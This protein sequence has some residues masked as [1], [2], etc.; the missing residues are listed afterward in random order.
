MKTRKRKKAGFAANTKNNRVP[1]LSSI[2]FRVMFTV[3]IAVFIA[4]TA[5]LLVVTLPVRSELNAVNSEYLYMT[6]VLYGQKLETAV[7]L[8]KR[9]ND[10]RQAPDRLASFLQNA[11]LERCESSYS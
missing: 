10:I 4:V 11:R 3:G 5:V 1:L 7:N 2:R 8:T 9:T 6:T